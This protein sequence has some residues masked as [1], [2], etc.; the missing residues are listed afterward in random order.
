VTTQKD[1]NKFVENR[2]STI[3]AI[4]FLSKR[5]KKPVQI[6]IALMLLDNCK[7]QHEPKTSLAIVNSDINKHLS[8]V[9][10]DLGTN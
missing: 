1:P 10:Q 6:K 4:K 5:V 7:S 8:D 3:S 2:K 9:R